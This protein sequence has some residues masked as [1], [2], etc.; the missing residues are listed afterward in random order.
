MFVGMRSQ[1]TLSVIVTSNI[2]A[3]HESQTMAVSLFTNQVCSLLGSFKVRLFLLIESLFII[4]GMVAD[5]SL[6]VGL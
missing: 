3:L 4:S 2:D 5:L 1:N 6:V